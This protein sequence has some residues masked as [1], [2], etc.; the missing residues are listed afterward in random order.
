MSDPDDC[1]RT[2]QNVS[3]FIAFV[4]FCAVVIWFILVW[5]LNIPLNDFL[6]F[7]I[8]FIPLIVFGIAISSLGVETM[9]REQE[10]NI[11]RTNYSSALTL[12]LSPILIWATTRVEDNKSFL[13]I[14][15][16]A[17]ALV[18]LT[19]YD[20]WVNTEWFAAIKHL[21]TIIQAYSITLMIFALKIFCTDRLRHADAQKAD[22]ELHDHYGKLF[23]QQ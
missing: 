2:P 21:R 8:F 14:V 6:D 3:P 15:I 4:Y 7:V 17:T 22:K 1:C 5:A 10:S 23:D 20:F 12:L 18:L 9:T 13:I 11:I 16:T 19:F